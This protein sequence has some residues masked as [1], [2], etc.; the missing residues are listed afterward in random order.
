MAGYDTQRGKS[1]GSQTAGYVIATMLGAPLAFFVAVLVLRS[2]GLALTVAVAAT[3]V[4]LTFA[5]RAWSE[6]RSAR[7]Y[8]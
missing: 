2:T 6:D 5:L 1:K 3:I 7:T 8:D 4:G